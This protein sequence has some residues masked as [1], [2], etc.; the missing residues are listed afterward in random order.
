MP[1]AAICSSMSIRSRSE[2]SGSRWV[3]S[4][5]ARISLMRSMVASTSVTAGAVTARPSRNRPISVS[6][7]WASAWS[8]GNPR[9]PHVPLMVWTRRKMLWR[10][11]ALLGS[12][13]KRT[14]ST[15]IRSRLSLVSVRNSRNNSSMTAPQAARQ[16]GARAPFTSAVSLL[17]N[18]LR[19]VARPARSPVRREIPRGF[20]KSA[21]HPR[22]KGNQC[23]AAAR[24]DRRASGGAD[25]HP[26]TVRRESHGQAAAAGQQA[27]VERLDRVRVDRGRT[28]L[29]GNEAGNRL[30]HAGIEAGGRHPK[31]R[32]LAVPDRIDRDGAAAGDRLIGENQQIEQQLDAILRQQQPRKIPRDLGLL[33][34]E[35]AARHGFGVAEIDRGSDRAG[36]AEREPAELQARRGLLRA[37]LDQVERESLGLLIAV[38]FQ[39]FEPVDE[40]ADR[41][42][43]VVANSRAQQGGEIEHFEGA[44]H[45]GLRSKC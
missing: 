1:P 43:Q 11:S 28:G 14:S 6:A 21:P 8:R 27:R 13:S 29:P 42:D 9:K 34:V 24:P 30:R 26:I 16:T 2:P 35:Q 4:S 40:G 3:R 33:V 25:H 15:S 38:V 20:L 45:A 12:C 37:L 41:A 44:V 39:H 31:A 17:V 36:G 18:G 32:D 23:V 19:L 22:A 10:I 5:S 7:E